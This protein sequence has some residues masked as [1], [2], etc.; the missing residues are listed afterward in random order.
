MYK[1]IDSRGNIYVIKSFRS[2]SKTSSKVIAR[3]GKLSEIMEKNNWTES[4]ALD[5]IQKEIRRLEAEDHEDSGSVVLT[6][7]KNRDIPLD[8]QPS[9]RTGHLFLQRVLSSLNLPAVCKDIQ[10]RYKIQFDLYAILSALVFNRILDPG[11]KLDA[12]EHLDEY[13][14][15]WDFSLNDIYRSLDVIAQNSTEIQSALFKE[16]MKFVDRDIATL[17]YDCS[18][19]YMEIEEA[20]DKLKQYGKSKENR[21]NPVIG[22][23][24][25]TD[26]EGIPIRM[27]LFPGN[28]PDVTTI[29]KTVINELRNKFDIKQFI[30]SADAGIASDAIKESLKHF[31]FPC[32]YV[33]TESIK[34]MTDANQAC[35]LGEDVDEDENW[36]FFH[37]YSPDLQKVVT[38]KI[39]FK[40]INEKEHGNII[41]FKEKWIKKDNQTK[42]EERLVVTYSPKYA[43]YLRTLREKHVGRAAKK[44]KTQG[45][46]KR[47]TDPA[48]FIKETHL[49]DEGEVAE[50]AVL[51]IDE[52]KVDKEARFDGFYCV[53]TNLEKAGIDQILSINKNRW[54]IEANFRTLK[55]DLNSRPIFLQNDERIKAHFLICF[56][57]LLTLRL[58]EKSL[59]F[60]Y[61]GP[62]I[63]EALRGMWMFKQKDLGYSPDFKRT[64]LT[65]HLMKRFDLPLSKEIISPERFAQLEKRSRMKMRSLKN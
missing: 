64:E 17:I 40:N 3:L 49:T 41:F 54:R 15:D 27:N 18:N 20:A 42:R 53:S 25:F 52:D 21:P 33:V 56:I 14:G 65:D 62:Q 58:I 9:F 22:M 6:L 61:S 2:G 39:L 57:G 1:R 29:D 48:R 4:E 31:C 13:Y 24:L 8:E 46:H 43:S 59:D 34:K 28:M 11:S 16:S 10:E 37:Q 7:S 45:K 55:T 30:Y 12:F 35:A 38:H 60:T 26:S 36:W 47:Q 51:E 23:G 19:F 44:I 5:W 32:G 50:K 63:L